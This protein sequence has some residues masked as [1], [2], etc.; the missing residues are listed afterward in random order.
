MCAM[1]GRQDSC[2]VRGRLQIK[3]VSLRVCTFV[4]V[5]VPL[6]GWVGCACCVLA[7]TMTS[8]GVYFVQIKLRQ[9]TSALAVQY[10]Y[11]YVQGPI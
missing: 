3:E 9:L 10:I 4:C 7:I 2:I 1:H 6:L 8:V 5:S 11:M